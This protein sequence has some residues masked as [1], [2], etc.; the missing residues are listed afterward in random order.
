M[1]FDP[2]RN[3]APRRAIRAGRIA[4]ARGGHTIELTDWKQAA[5]AP[6][7]SLTPDEREHLKAVSVSD[8]V[9]RQVAEDESK[10]SRL[11]KY[12]YKTQP[13]HPRF[14]RTWGADESSF[15]H[16]SI[17]GLYCLISAHSARKTPLSCH[18]AGLRTQLPQG[19]HPYQVVGGHVQHKNLIHFLQSPHHHLPDTADKFGPAKT[20]FD[21]FSFVL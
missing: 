4:L 10:P 2:Q 3:S 20:L 16:M 5:T 1:G 12:P 19:S 15:N 13:F 9:I 7:R 17:G 18:C 6:D 14:I 11:L 21:Q 8:E